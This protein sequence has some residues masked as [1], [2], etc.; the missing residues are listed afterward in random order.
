MCLQLPRL[1]K[2]DSFYLLAYTLSRLLRKLDLKFYRVSGTFEV[3]ATSLPSFCALDTMVQVAGVCFPG[4]NLHCSWAF[5]DSPLKNFFYGV[6]EKAAWKDVREDI[7]VERNDRNVEC[8]FFQY[9]LNMI[10]ISSSIPSLSYNEILKLNYVIET[11]I[12]F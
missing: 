11:C 3:R 5:F 6:I 4:Q 9:N 7:V 2:L 10:L 8:R 1:T 12:I